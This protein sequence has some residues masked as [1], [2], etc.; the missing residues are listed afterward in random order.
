MNTIRE[1]LWPLPKLKASLLGWG[2][3]APALLIMGALVLW[4]LAST[5]WDSFYSVNPMKVGKPFVGLDNYINLLS[6]PNV[7]QAWSNTFLYVLF[8]VVIET[9]L[10]VSAALLL[11]KVKFGR[12]WLLAALILPWCLPP[13][14]NAIV[15]GWIFNPSYGV[16]NNALL[17]MGVISE[18]K[19]WFN[20]RLSALF[21]ISVV[22]AWRMMPLTAIIILAA[23]QSIP[24]ELYEAAKLDGAGA[25][26]MFRKITLPLIASGLAIALSQSTVFAF[27]MFDEAW[28]MNGT[29]YDTR[30]VMIQV[31]M[32]AFQNLKFSYGMALSI[33][34]MLASLIISAVYVLRVYRETRFD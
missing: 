14:V 2:Y 30:S 22:H 23:L 32:S 34:A 11:N 16:L 4:P 15:W 9:V 27:N 12:S 3:V 28:I 10:G 33:M 25:I 1:K 6:D 24:K 31:Y 18:N 26:K 20:E 13:V 8:T 29:G 21:M 19:V 17:S 7:R 5:I